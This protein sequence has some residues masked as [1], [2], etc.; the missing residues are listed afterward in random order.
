MSYIDVK[1]INMISTRLEKFSWKTATLA[2]CRCPMCGDSKKNKSKRRFYFYYKKGEF[3]AKC[4][5]CE[6]ANLF[7]TFLKNY[8]PELY[9]EYRMEIFQQ[10]FAPSKPEI[11]VSTTSPKERFDKAI[12]IDLPRIS[13]LPPDHIAVRYL[14]DRKVPSILYDE[15]YYSEDFESFGKSINDTRN[16]FSDPKIVI[17]FKQKDGSVYGVICRTLNKYSKYRYI[18]I[19][20]EGEERELIYGIDKLDIT[21]KI[22]IL[23]GPIDSMMIPNAIA[24][25]G[26]KVMTES[27]LPGDKDLCVFVYDN[28]PRNKDVINRVSGA[29]EHGYNVCIWPEYIKE[30]D[31]NDMILNGINAQQII[32]E[33][34]Y[35]GLMAKVKL[36]EW[37]KV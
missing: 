28:E 18:I 16:Y 23:E 29:I 10:S 5:N 11:K 3:H 30:K 27:S 6:I 4:H 9:R 20:P 15:I 12:F 7:S 17:P 14:T 36:I 1:Y 34:T 25:S 26:L 35:S 13:D 21:S 32:D 2:T 33:N 19:K 22:Y 8:D 24:V 37:S 31:V